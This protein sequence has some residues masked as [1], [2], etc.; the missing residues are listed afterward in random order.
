MCYKPTRPEHEPRRESKDDDR[1]E[2]EPRRPRPTTKP[3]GN[4]DPDRRD[5]D[6]G[7]E[8]LHAVLGQ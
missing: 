8:R 4:G 5:I 2:H 7:A 3:R 6:R 1:R